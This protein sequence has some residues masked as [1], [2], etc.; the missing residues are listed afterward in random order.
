MIQVL[1]DHP[2]IDEFDLTGLRRIIYGA[3]PMSEGVLNRAVKALPNATFTQA[4]GMTEL[5]P[6]ATLLRPS[7]HEHPVHRR[8][9]GRAVLHG[10]VRILGPD[11]VEVPRGS[12]GEICAAGG[13]VMLGYWDRPEET[14]EALRG[15]WMHTGDGGYMDDDGYVYIADRIKDMIITGGENVY[16]VE[17]ENVIAQHPAVATAAVIGVPD[18][19]WGERVHA[20][21]VPASGATVTLEELT[22]FCRERMA[23]YKLPRSM[24]LVDGLPVSAAGKVLKR[25]LRKPFWAGHDRAVH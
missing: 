13:H 21:V 24:E 3:S 20:V 10:E 18:E 22:E 4:Y 25:E 5:S 14:A 15:G 6:C 7:D 1:V 9:A 8:S 19:R 23:G 2:R 11:D 12:V 16:S 17:V